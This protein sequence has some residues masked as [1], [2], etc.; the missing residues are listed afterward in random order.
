MCPAHIAFS[1]PKKPKFPWTDTFEDVE[2]AELMQLIIECR[3][4]LHSLEAEL[5]ARQNPRVDTK[6]EDCYARLQEKARTIKHM[7]ALSN[8]DRASLEEAGTFLEA[9]RSGYI[10]SSQTRETRK[11]GAIYEQLLWL[12]S[13]VAG[14]AYAL[15][16][17]C[18][19]TR[20]T[21]ERL[22]SFQSTILVKRMARYYN[23]LSNRALEEKANEFGLC[24]TNISLPDPDD[25]G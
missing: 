1:T 22:N 17:I 16:L 3:G 13:R 8:M 21:V 9:L 2:N 14:P 10:D 7:G 6:L 18:S 12:I 5:A 23:S 15:L 24:K 4:A 19:V 25:I 11:G 20:R